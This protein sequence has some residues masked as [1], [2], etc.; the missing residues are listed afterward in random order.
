MSA[1][2]KDSPLSDAGRAYL[3]HRIAIDVARADAGAYLSSMWNTVQVELDPRVKE[4]PFEHL[5]TLVARPKGSQHDHGLWYQFKI[6][7]HDPMLKEIRGRGLEVRLHDGQADAVSG[8]SVR[9]QI[10]FSST[11]DGVSFKKQ[12]AGRVRTL[13]DGLSKQFDQTAVIGRSRWVLAEVDWKLEFESA[14]AD[15]QLVTS[16]TATVFRVVAA[17]LDEGR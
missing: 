13:V 11:D 7:D 8:T 16:N 3:E 2:L 5:K 9:A 4:F 10:G 15:S 17:C 14:D 12:H 6:P 1:N